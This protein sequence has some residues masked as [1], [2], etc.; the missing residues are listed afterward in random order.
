MQISMP[1]QTPLT[2]TSFSEFVSAHQFAVIHFWASWNAYDIQMR[3]LIES[4]IPDEFRECVAFAM[5]DIDPAEHHEICRQHRVLNVPFLA[6]YRAGSLVR[7]ET[8]LP[9][10]ELFAGFLRD[11]VHASA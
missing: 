1:Q 7:T 9:K 6:F 2:H 5:F 8:G 11:L 3:R 10:P 4:Q